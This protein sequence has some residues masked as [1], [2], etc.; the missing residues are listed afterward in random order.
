MTARI[1][2]G[3]AL[4]DEWLADIAEEVRA[5]GA[6]LGLAALCPEGDAA[7]ASFVRLKQR[8]AQSVGVQF[9]SYF[10]ADEAQARQTLGYLAA[11]DTIHGIFVE[12]PLPAAWD[13]EALLHLIPAGKDVDALRPAGD[14]P[15]APPAVTALRRLLDAEGIAVPGLRV[16]VIGQGKLVGEPIAKW[17]RE[18]GAE[19][20]VID[21]DTP[22]PAA[23][24]AHAD[25]L[26][27]GA[28]KAG[29]V[30]GDWVNEGATVVDFGW[31]DGKGDADAAS[32]AKKA[33]AFTPVPGGMGP[34]VVAAVLENLVELAT[35]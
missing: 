31:Q 17:L 20:D 33:G 24:A 19:T 4:A 28:G 34:L 22:S 11:D 32:V 13:A 15:V 16:A 35:H 1:I 12:L 10:V 30:T 3:K 5:L 9:S 8:A 21:V 14:A 29:L 23:V 2:D 7:L 6:S 27:C 26:V 18:H 25:V